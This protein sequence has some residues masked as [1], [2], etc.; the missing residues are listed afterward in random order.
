[1]IRLFEVVCFFCKRGPLGHRDDTQA[2]HALSG[3]EYDALR[4]RAAQR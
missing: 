4:I 2:C 1:M 3:R